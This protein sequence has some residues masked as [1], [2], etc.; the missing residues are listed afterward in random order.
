MLLFDPNAAASVANAEVDIKITCDSAK[1]FQ[2]GGQVRAIV[3]YIELIP[4]N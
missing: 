1:N 4:M 2:A 3:Y